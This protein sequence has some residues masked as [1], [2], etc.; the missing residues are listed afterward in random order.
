MG[1]A[2]NVSLKESGEGIGELTPPYAEIDVDVSGDVN[3]KMIF[4]IPPKSATA[5]G[6]LMLAGEGEEKEEM[7]EEDLDAIKEIVSN[8]LGSLS[9]PCLLNKMFQI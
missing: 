2:P 4:L 9:L 3:G 7:N 1:I 5:L 6:D 8:I